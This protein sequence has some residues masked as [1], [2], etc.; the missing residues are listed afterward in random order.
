MIP[1]LSGKHNPLVFQQHPNTS[2]F[3]N[4]YRKFQGTKKKME[5]SHQTT[6]QNGGQTQEV[7]HYPI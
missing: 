4:S 5:F 6:K 3:S 2:S 1:T 7:S